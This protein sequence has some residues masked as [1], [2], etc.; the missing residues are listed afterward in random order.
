MST[1]KDVAKRKAYYQDHYENNKLYYYE[2]NKRQRQ[3]KTAWIAEQKNKPCAD[4]GNIYH[5]CAMDFDHLDPALK[6]KDVSKLATFGWSRIKQE[7]AKCELVCANCH[8]IRT[9][10]RRIV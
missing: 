1:V 5:P 2:R 3:L 10:N 8:R 4:C 6:D 9:Y 7:I